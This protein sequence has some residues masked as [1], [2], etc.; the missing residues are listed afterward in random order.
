MKVK[1]VPD[2]IVNDIRTSFT[3]SLPVPGLKMEDDSFQ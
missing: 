1:S 2:I 3:L